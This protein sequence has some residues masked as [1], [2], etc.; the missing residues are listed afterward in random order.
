MSGV[1][2]RVLPALYTKLREGKCVTYIGR[3]GPL[4]ALSAKVEEPVL[5]RNCL[6]LI[7]R[8]LM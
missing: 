1:C 2:S 3:E 6:R 8:C 7:E 4:M 5:V